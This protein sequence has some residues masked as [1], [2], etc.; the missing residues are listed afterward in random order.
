MKDR[1]DSKVKYIF[2]KKKIHGIALFEE[3][4]SAEQGEPA[5]GIIEPASKFAEHVLEGSSLEHHAQTRF[6]CILIGRVNCLKYEIEET[7]LALIKGDQEAIKGSFQDILRVRRFL[8]NLRG[9]RTEVF[10]SGRGNFENLDPADYP[11]IVLFDGCDSFDKWQGVFK[12][13][14]IIALFD[15]TQREFKESVFQFN[16]DHN[17]DHGDGSDYLSELAA[18][19]PPGMDLCI[20]KEKV[21]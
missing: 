1:V 6:E 13:A 10:S 17:M 20:H 16:G 3:N 11:G 14:S 12:K 21:K 2:L 4:D 19:V 5:G 7:E 9:F 15:R 18:D 8:G